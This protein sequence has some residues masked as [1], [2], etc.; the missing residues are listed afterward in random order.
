M[1]SLAGQGP[2]LGLEH[3]NQ[4]PFAHGKGNVAQWL[5]RQSVDVFGIDDHFIDDTINLDAWLLTKDTNATSFA[6]DLGVG[7]RV[8][9]ITSTT[10]NSLASL[11]GPAI[12]RGDEAV[13][14]VTSGTKSLTLG[15]MIC[16]A[17]I[18]R[19]LDGETDGWEVEI[20]TRRY[21]LARTALPFYSRTR[22]K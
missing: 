15:K 19:A 7:G 10:D 16:M 22:K 3:M 20:S 8:K 6:V 21:P 5:M 17:Y 1:M 12:Y 13:G 14:K 18:P 11:L 9:A 2:R 4:I